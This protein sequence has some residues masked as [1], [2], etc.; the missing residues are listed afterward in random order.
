LL[1]RSHFF[2]W[3]PHA[4]AAA[5]ALQQWVVGLHGP[6][7][8]SFH[9]ARL[10]HFDGCERELEVLF[11]RLVDRA[12]DMC[13][14]AGPP[15]SGKTAL[16]HEFARRAGAFFRDVF[17]LSCGDRTLPWLS[18]ELGMS[19]GVLAES[20]SQDAWTRT[21]RAI[22]SHRI[23]LVLDEA[24][25][26]IVQPYLSGGHA[27]LLV[28]GHAMDTAD[29]IRLERRRPTAIQA[30]SHPDDLRLW[31][32][33]S[34][35]SPR[36]I[37][38][39]FAAEAAGLDRSEAAQAAGRLVAARLADP[40]DERS[41]SFRVSRSSRRAAHADLQTSALF[42]RHAEVLRAALSN[43]TI[44]QLP[45][46][47][48]WALAEEWELGVALAKRSF[49]FLHRER[50]MLESIAVMDQLRRAAERRG[51]EALAAECRWELSWFQDTA[52][53]LRPAPSVGE[54]LS[55]F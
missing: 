37:P 9:P 11:D 25:E 28:T 55:L 30:P 19:A 6:A 20:E 8:T 31:R 27:S 51:D 39:E 18:G 45:A 32:A 41:R 5:R 17:W 46:A 34:V 38:L 47:L 1:E 35:C 50:R 49:A 15:E 26:Q 2:R 33:M 14:V 44:P 21:A 12:G 48:R 43:Q 36:E 23:L 40:V 52:G 7:E 16:A 22:T 42:R 13:L 3:A 4:T 54:Q 24:G 10:P 53:A 29:S